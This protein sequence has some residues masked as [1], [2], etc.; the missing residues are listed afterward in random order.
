MKNLNKIQVQVR[1]WLYI[2]PISNKNISMPIKE[3]YIIICILI[4]WKNLSCE[5]GKTNLPYCVKNNISFTIDT[6]FE[7]EIWFM[8]III[9]IDVLWHDII[10]RNIYSSVC[11]WPNT[12]YWLNWIWY[13]CRVQSLFDWIL[14]NSFLYNVSFPL[15]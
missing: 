1:I 8:K 11:L 13:K 12:F 15:D 4:Y 5:V 10:Y 3:S 9:S 6:F 14:L 2:E 7:V